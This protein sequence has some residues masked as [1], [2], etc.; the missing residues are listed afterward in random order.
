MQVAARV[1]QQVSRPRV[2]SSRKAV[3]VQAAAK[4]AESKVRGRSGRSSAVSGMGPVSGRQ[5]RSQH[6]L[7]RQLIGQLPA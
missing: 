4:P 5:A 6:L 7:R 2:S 3:K 1:S